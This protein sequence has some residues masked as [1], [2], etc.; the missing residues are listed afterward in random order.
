MHT[1]PQNEDKFTINNLLYCCKA[2]IFTLPL[3]YEFLCGPKH[4]AT[5]VF[6][7]S[8]GEF[9]KCKGILVTRYNLLVPHL[10]DSLIIFNIKIS[11]LLPSSPT[12]LGVKIQISIPS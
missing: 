1:V 2:L 5:P 3:V 7:I 10:E 6:G 11:V 12:K 9:G 8:I 4:M